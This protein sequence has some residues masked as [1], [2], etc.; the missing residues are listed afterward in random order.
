MGRLREVMAALLVTMLSSCGVTANQPH[1]VFILADDLG[2]SEAQGIGSTL[3]R[4]IK[5]AG[6]TV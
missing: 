6:C 2:K 5:F 1:I 3:L 4:V